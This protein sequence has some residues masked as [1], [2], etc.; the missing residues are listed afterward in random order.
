MENPSVPLGYRAFARQF[1]QLIAPFHP[2][3]KHLIWWI[4]AVQVGAL[5]EPFIIKFVIDD[6]VT[7][8]SSAQTRLPWLS[9]IALATFALLSVVVIEKNR[10]IRKL[11]QAI[12]C[13]LPLMCGEKLL[14]LP[15]VYH[16]T[17]HSETLV[18]KIVKGTGR[19][20]D[21]VAVMSFEIVPLIIQT[22]VTSV[23]VTIF[24]WRVAC[25]IIPITMLFAMLTVRLKRKLAPLRE[26]R[27]ALDDAADTELGQAI[28]NVMT[29]QAF[30][31]EER[32][33]DRVA[34]KRKEVLELADREYHQAERTEHFRNG[35]I[36]LGRILTIAV[37]AGSVYSGR[38]TVGT[39]AFVVAL[40]ERVFINCY[41]IN[42][43]FDRVSEAM[44][45]VKKMTEIMDEPIQI[46]D[47]EHPVVVPTRFKGKI[48]FERL[49]YRY[50][51]RHPNG[52][53]QRAALEGVSHVIP[54]GS[55][56]GVPGPSGG[57]KSTLARM[58]LR[59]DDPEAGRVT[60]DGID[61]RDM[62]LRDFRQQIGYVPQEV[63]IFDCTIAENIAFGRPN[64]T[65][66]EI[67]R[68]AEIAHAHEFI[69][70]LERGY[71]TVVGNRGL[72]LSGGQRQRVGIA[73]AVLLD[74]P[75]L[76]F[77][78]ATS[79]VDTI[80]E[81]KIQRAIDG[82]RRDRTVLIIAHRLST[83]QNADRIAVLERGR[84][85]EVGTHQELVQRGSGTYGRLAQLQSQADAVA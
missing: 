43:I 31:Q 9:A 38:M 74:P 57:G 40:A 66:E 24:E 29:V 63:E 26:R 14:R 27:Y 15:L 82:L 37:C 11:W 19:V 80:S 50:R 2:Q 64:A 51:L 54:A 46:A 3:A 23:I 8:G 76:I 33:L 49:T 5:F 70:L 32:Q 53:P 10:R 85:Q 42:T 41:R 48:A 28:T 65:R 34:A 20:T 13:R 17:E 7:H 35:L 73:R 47:P 22:V 81:Q 72:R 60:I 36:S 30:A 69:L 44:E 25:V 84:I 18:S 58:L 83:I 61:L 52:N 16:Q 59:F 67:I 1:W 62:P 12:D 79:H 77:D 6:I 56:E 71:D 45:P 68:A 75:I 78:E 55:M 21:I 4:V 39:L